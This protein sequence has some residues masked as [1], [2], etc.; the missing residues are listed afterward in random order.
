MPFVPR[1]RTCVA[2]WLFI[3]A[4]ACSAALPAHA[5]DASAHFDLVRD[6]LTAEGFGNTA[7][8]VV[9]VTNWMD[10][11]YEQAS[12]NP[13]SLHGEMWLTMIGAALVP[14]GLEGW[15]DEVVHAADWLGFDGTVR[16][17]IGGVERGADSGEIC[18]MEW[19][20]LARAVKA[21]AR[22]RASAG[23]IQGLLTILGI[24][25]H[26]LQDFY[27]HSNWVEPAGTAS[28]DG[29]DGPG[30]AAMGTYGSH[31]TWFDVPVEVRR[32]A[33]VYVDD[34]GP[35]LRTH[36]GWNS[37]GNRNLATAMNKD[38]PGRPLYLDAYITAYFATRQWVRAVRSWVDDEAVWQAAQRFSDRHAGQLDHDLRGAF[39]VQFN[40]GHWQ[41]QGEPTGGDAPGPGGSLDDLI[42]AVAGYHTVPKTTFRA[43]FERVVTQVGDRTPPPAETPVAS[44]RDLQS[45]VEFVVAQVTHVR[46]ATPWYEVGV[47]P[48]LDEAD[49]YAKANI[50]GQEFCS[51]MI[52]GYDVCGFS[53]PSYPFTFVKAVPLA[54]RTDEPVT[55]LQV[56][57]R[58]RD[59]QWAGTDDDVFL[60]INDRQRFLLDKPLYD[61]FE[62]GD[63][64]TYSINPPAG[65]RVSDVQYL[66][67]EK[68]PDG[69]A[70]GWR[71]S[72]VALHVNAEQV[73][74]KDRIDKWLE[75]NDRTWRAPDFRP[76]APMTSDVPV[77]LRLYDSDG[78]LY[79]DDDH[80]DIHS[81]FNR[82][83]LNLLYNRDTSAFRG[84][85]SGTTT[86]MS[87]GGSRHG[88]RWP[89][90][91]D[92][93][94]CEIRFAFDRV[95]AAPP[96]L[97]APGLR[98]ARFPP[99]APVVTDDGEWTRSADGLRAS[100]R[101][102]PSVNAPPP[103][104]YQYRVRDRDT[105][106]ARDWTSVGPA[107]SAT[108][109]LPLRHGHVYFIDVKAR[110]E[111]GWSEVGCSDGVAADLDPP[112][113]GI[114]RFEQTSA[115]PLGVATEE[116]PRVFPNSFRA[117]LVASDTG[118]SGFDAYLC[119]ITERIVTE[120][121]AGGDLRDVAAPRLPPATHVLFSAE[122]AAEDTRDGVVVLRDVPG[123]RSGT[124]YTLR[125]RGRDHAG[126]VGDEATATCV[127][128]FNDTTP[129]PAPRP[130][131]VSARPLAMTW[132]EVHD[133]ESGIAEYR[134]AAASDASLVDAP[135][136]LRW[137]SVGRAL[138]FSE[139]ELV[140]PKG[141][142]AW[143][144]AING[145]GQES[146]GTVGPAIPIVAPTRKVPALPPKQAP[147]I[148]PSNAPAPAPKTAPAK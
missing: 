122:I 111:I 12:R 143:V 13:Y 146:V 96:L 138:Q 130:R 93:D 46:D 18:E 103:V 136:L 33:R 5:L 77:T 60:R 117:A 63:E 28:A 30:W 49:F 55:S 6:A 62:R 92:N 89:D 29:Y 91:M 78:W 17:T 74:Y 107:T 119:A 22:D 15:S 76:R 129:P 32:A 71:L 83:D 101:V 109:A 116:P 81:D 50:A 44:T 67:I 123:L 80:C 120:R 113:V 106:V 7:I 112:R 21:A 99:A 42:G 52:H 88:G 37:D 64:D 48:G 3:L 100:W 36:G 95:R 24:S 19:N 40:S 66:Q 26:T 98:P 10:D 86:G 97:A 35:G 16:Y 135:D 68:A 85:V 94:N 20:R 43:G 53:L 114:N 148:A 51:G 73:Y 11:Y 8:E 147:P 1:L 140:L 87:Q 59:E 115:W 58:T 110:N 4:V 108:V 104:E 75:D 61:D 121:P 137:R 127:V 25:S 79:G 133:Q 57:V 72:R 145:M 128:R 31:P 105:G 2:T 9:Q 134:V 141:A 27:V 125:V 70:G 142:C 90:G 102:P 41:G 39:T 139:V 38:W 45:T 82:Y 84:D 118:R 144:K 126:N 23:D 34:G 56:T 14:W 124:T 131:V 47:D 65:L 69:T 54:W 132:D